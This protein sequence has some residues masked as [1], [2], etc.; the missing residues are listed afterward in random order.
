MDKLRSQNI[1]PDSSV[2]EIL[3]ETLDMLETLVGGV[4]KQEKRE[5]EITPLIDRLKAI[6]LVGP[7][8]KPEMAKE[9]PG[10]VE[11]TGTGRAQKRCHDKKRL[12]AVT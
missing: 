2:I 7:P 4:A 1:K 6:S 8:L 9:E 5:I 3:F 11:P 10:L 12:P